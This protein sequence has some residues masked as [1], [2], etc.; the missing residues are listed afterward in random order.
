MKNNKAMI[1][2]EAKTCVKFMS[3]F[4]NCILNF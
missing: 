4:R 3:N 1:E 2:I